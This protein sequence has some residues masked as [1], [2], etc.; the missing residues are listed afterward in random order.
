MKKNKES[1]NL[2][3]IAQTASIVDGADVLTAAMPD[4]NII[5]TESTDSTRKYNYNNVPPRTFKRNE[6]GLLEETDYIFNEDGTVN[7]R[8]MIPVQYLYLNPQ[9]TE[10]IETE[11]GKKVSEISITDDKVKDRDLVITLNGIRHLAFL[12]GF[13]EYNYMVNQ[14]SNEYASVVCRIYWIQNYETPKT[15]ETQDIYDSIASSGIGSAN[16]L[17]TNQMTR[18][19]LVEMAENRAFCRAVRAFLRISIVSQEELPPKNTNQQQE[20][21]PTVINS[22]AAT[23][24]STLESRKISFDKMKATLILRAKTDE[25]KNKIEKYKSVYD[26]PAVEIFDILGKIKAKEEQKKTIVP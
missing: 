6:Y 14:S 7:W 24:L 25:E 23:L 11:Y 3:E 15:K 9:H 19:Y 26:I 16:L 5:P 17:T 22:P 8:A 21:Q 10:R 1:N 20:E 4:T 12:R 18:N 2:Q 13:T